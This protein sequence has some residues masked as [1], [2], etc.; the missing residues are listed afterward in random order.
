M[1]SERK[2]LWFIPMAALTKIESEILF[3]RL[4]DQNDIVAD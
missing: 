3:P 2:H 4:R 1:L